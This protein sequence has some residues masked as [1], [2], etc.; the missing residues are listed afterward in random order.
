MEIIG[1]KSKYS[2]LAI[3]E[4][5]EIKFILENC[6]GKKNFIEIGTD[7]GGTFA[8]IAEVVKGKCITVD[9]ELG[10]FGDKGVDYKAR[11]SAFKR[12]IKD[13]TIISGDSHCIDTVEQVRT[14]LDGEL[15]EVLFID[16][17][18][19]YDGVKADYLNYKQ[20]VADNGIIIFH[21]IIESEFHK[22]QGCRVDKFWNELHGEKRQLISTDRWMGVG[23]IINKIIPEPKV[24]LA[25]LILYYNTP[26]LITDL[27]RLMPDAIIIDNGSAGHLSY[28]GSNR[29]IKLD[30]NYGFTKG[31]NKAIKELSAEFDYFWL[32]NSD[33]EV[34]QKCIEQIEKRCEQGYDLFTPAF[35][36]CHNS[37]KEA[38]TKKGMVEVFE[39]EFTAPVI[40]RKCISLVGYLDESLS[41]GHAIDYDYCKRALQYGI[42]PYVDNSCSFI[43][44][45]HKSISNYADYLNFASSEVQINMRQKYGIPWREML[46]GKDKEIPF[47][48][49]ICCYTTIFGDYD[50]PKNIINQ[51]LKNI[52]YF[53]IT[54][55]PN[56]QHPQYKTIVVDFPRKDLHNNLQ[57]KFH[58]FFP[59]ENK[60]L[61]KYYLFIFIDAGIEIK[62]VNYFEQLINNFNNDIALYAHPDR[63]CIKDECSVSLT[64][65]KYKTE[66][67][68]VQTDDYLKS[69]PEHW[70]LYACGIQI[71]KNNDIVNNLMKSWWHECIKYSFQDQISL[72]FILNK[73]GIK[74]DIIKGNI[75]EC[76]NSNNSEIVIHSHGKNKI[77][78]VIP[79]YTWEIFQIY[80]NEK[81]KRGLI[82]I[83]EPYDNSKD[84][85]FLFFENNVILDI[86]NKLDEIE[87]DYVGTTSWKFSQKIQMSTL[88]FV[89]AVKNNI[90][91][92]EVLLFPIQ[93][94]M[95]EDCVQRNKV[96]YIQL[97][98]LTELFDN[99]N[100]LPF[101]MTSDKW[102]CSYCNFWLAK[103]SV[104]KDYCEKVLLPAMKAFMENEKIKQFVLDNPF[105]HAGTTYP[106]APFL[107]ELLMGF[108]VNKFNITHTV[109]TPNEGM[110]LKSDEVW[111]KVLNP[112]LIP[113]GKTQVKFKRSFAEQL[114]ASGYVK[115]IA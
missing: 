3:Q 45:V 77:K 16:G 74:P 60:E 102:T 33:I 85:S 107:L 80:Y 66:N 68:R 106:I 96:F 114:Q 15:A 48:Y 2:Y 11:N 13:V 10:S 109:I 50:E 19:T 41:K 67:I 39:F 56:I 82:P 34:T 12:D 87:S 99:E 31:W 94:H 100:I 57:A 104:Y 103:K 113:E 9:L 86:Y 38:M 4:E 20:F 49:K 98:Q 97:Y 36:C 73:Q 105:H 24:K 81:S 72:P 89:D 62:K 6:K 53:I 29:C 75:H 65:D 71:K 70:G 27:C 83:F 108:Y 52:D 43:H 28:K 64:L 5:P 79:K 78:A 69:L 17:D 35:N 61:S 7:Y 115:I 26:D 8:A 40:S 25:K 54:D 21:D 1:K 84:K 37:V 92:N 101:K 18:H 59:Q 93:K 111:C 90:N 95:N 51:T 42:K 91:D 76:Y 32:M 58:K 23:I 30:R 46:L 44:K 63:D 47:D 110:K 88:E 22:I 112:A 55:N 14:A